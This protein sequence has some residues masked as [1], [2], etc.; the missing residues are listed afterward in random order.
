MTARLVRA[1]FERTL[2]RLHIARIIDDFGPTPTGI[3]VYLVP[4]TTLCDLWQDEAAMIIHHGRKE[5]NDRWDVSDVVDGAIVTPY[6][7]IESVALRE[8]AL[9]VGLDKARCTIFFADHEADGLDHRSIDLAD[10]LVTIELDPIL[11]VEA[12]AL[13]GRTIDAA[14]AAA[15]IALPWRRRLVALRSKRDISETARMNAEI[16]AAENI[17]KAATLGSPKAG[18]GRR[19]PDVPPLEEM[20]GY[21]DAKTWALELA[22]DIEDW[23][24]GKVTWE[25][26]DRGAMISGPPGCGKTTFASSLARTLGAHFVSG[27]YSSWLGNGNGHQGDLL[28]AMQAAFAE[29][30]KHA[31]TVLLID[32]VD[33]F[34]T[35]GSLSSARHDDWNRGVVN[36]LLECLDGANS[37]EGVI[38]IGATNDA[39]I[40]D[41][42]VRRPGRL[43]RHFEIPTPD[44]H[45]RGGIL[46]QHLR[47]DL[48]VATLMERTEGM[49]GADLER[50]ARDARR[51]ARRERVPVSLGHVEQQLPVLQPR[52]PEELRLIALHELG[53]AVVNEVIGTDHL[54]GIRV[55]LCKHEHPSAAGMAGFEQIDVAHR[56]RHF[57]RSKIARLLGG[58]AA[59]KL[60]FD[61]HSD[62][63]SEDLRAASDIATHMLAAVGMGDRLATT[64]RAG[65]IDLSELRRY[66]LSLYRRV[67]DLLQDALT[68]AMDV[69]RDYRFLLE[70]LADDLV[71]TGYLDGS[72]VRDAVARYRADA[73][74]SLAV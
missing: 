37:R 20:Y 22:R 26:V 47:A 68:R 60:F 64:V 49:S 51:A 58:I 43:D 57:Y 74:Q 65:E 21:G 15:L 32:E 67:D 69:V 17:A 70:R 50:L 7:Y 27:S 44:I 9:D 1:D 71:R 33:N 36:A 45:A 14:E 61:E 24:A 13:C 66:D 12:A 29:A 41:P 40:I 55:F 35:R 11:V 19:V 54:L 39:S 25:D 48:D 63:C 52:T 62:G 38:V 42:A 8:G 6:H 16:Q 5:S 72:V 46:R 10:N 34:P 3:H 28:I 23:R 53:H 59:E 73:Q 30:R 56:D 2:A 4:Q 18:D 31:P